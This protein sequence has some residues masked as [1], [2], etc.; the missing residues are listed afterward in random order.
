[1]CE[2]DRQ[3]PNSGGWGRRFALPQRRTAAPGCF[4]GHEEPPARS[5]V[6]WVVVGKTL[7]PA[8]AQRVEGL[9]GAALQHS[10]PTGAPAL[11]CGP[12][13][14]PRCSSAAAPCHSR[15]A[16]HCVLTANLTAFLSAHKAREGL[17]RKQHVLA[18]VS[19]GLESAT[20]PAAAAGPRAAGGGRRP[21][22]RPTGGRPGHW[23]AVRILP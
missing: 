4:R 15:A 2:R 21:S 3:G 6:G 8:R 12:R 9:A 22:H 1:M 20:R 19:S 18:S 17:M 5:T 7:W 16:S 10:R 23:W 14:H 13:P 11:P